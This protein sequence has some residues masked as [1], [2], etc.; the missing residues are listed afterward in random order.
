MPA[1]INVVIPDSYL[2]FPFDI[3]E[4]EYLGEK[5]LKVVTSDV[6]ILEVMFESKINR[7]SWHFDFSMFSSL[8][9]KMT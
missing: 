3:K 9:C 1:S 8:S 6:L 2:V 7:D 4:L 5:N